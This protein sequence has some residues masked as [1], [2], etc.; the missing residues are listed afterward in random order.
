MHVRVVVFHVAYHTSLFIK[1][2]N[3]VALGTRV[4]GKISTD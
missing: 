2:Y 1:V 4:K 3:F